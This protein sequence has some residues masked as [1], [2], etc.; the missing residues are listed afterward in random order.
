MEARSPD[1]L[2]PLANPPNVS[3]PDS[4]APTGAQSL[5]GRPCDAGHAEETDVWWGSYAGR[6]MVPGFLLCALLTVAV[7]GVAWSLG[8]WHGS[9]PARYA[10]QVC[11]VVLWG[12]QVGRWAYRLLALNYRLTTQRLFEDRGFHHPGSLG[13]ELDQITQVV[14]ERGPLERLLGVGRVR[15]ITQASSEQILV[16]EGIRNAEQVAAEIRRRV[17]HVRNQKK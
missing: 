9:A 4:L 7:V 15:V 14:V 12:A 6:T 11:I 17:Q 8:A 16:L 2:T 5:P 10:A 13:I 3:D 1:Q